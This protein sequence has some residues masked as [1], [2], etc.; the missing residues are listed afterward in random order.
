MLPRLRYSLRRCPERHPYP[1]ARLDNVPARW[2]RLASIDFSFGSTLTDLSASPLLQGQQLL[3]TFNPPAI[4]AQIPVFANHPMTRDC[5]RYGICRAGPGNGAG[6]IRHADLL[7][8]SAVGTC[9]A[10]WT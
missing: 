9:L 7:R 4:A 1:R 8:D 6:R 2:L 5:R 10:T 3:L